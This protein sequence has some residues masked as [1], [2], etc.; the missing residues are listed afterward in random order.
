M[1]TMH[2]ESAAHLCATLQAPY[3]K[4][5][6]AIKALGIEPEQSLN[7][8]NYYGIESCERIEEFV[9][10]ARDKKAKQ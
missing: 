6:S 10:A 5:Q 1:T 8:I 9:R 2:L 4:I 3:G 7:G